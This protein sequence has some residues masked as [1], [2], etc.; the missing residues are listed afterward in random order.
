[1][2]WRR[3]GRSFELALEA[4]IPEE[5][6]TLLANQA[7]DTIRYE[8]ALGLHPQTDELS[9]MT[10]RALLKIASLD[11]PRGLTL[12]PSPPFP[13]STILTPKAV[14]GTKTVV[15]KIFDGSD[16]F[17]DE[18]GK[19]WDHSFKLGPR[20]SALANLPEDESK[21]PVS[22]WLKGL[23]TDGVQQIILNSLLIRKASPP[24]QVR[25]FKPDGSNLPWVIA[26]LE[27]RGPERVQEW[28]ADVRTALPDLENVRTVERP[29]DKHR[30]LVL[31][32]QG[33]LDVPSW[34]VSDGTLRLLAL[35][36]PAYLQDFKGVYLDED[37]SRPPPPVANEALPETVEHVNF[38]RGA[39]PKPIAW[40]TRP[41]DLVSQDQRP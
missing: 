12:F 4:R 24:G 15:N 14:K 3:E 13:P 2:V 9:I 26:D 34:M 10:E 16:N 30:Y 40:L 8:V 37:P 20:K 18:M 22:T 33:G 5:R 11:Q 7:F 19:G 28:I 6:R 27:R 23:L 17:Y 21:F 38:A 41:C 31:R 39:G 29:D 25:G 35:T 1:L 36:L 32:Y